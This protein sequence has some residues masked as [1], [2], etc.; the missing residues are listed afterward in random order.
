MQ[1]DEEFEACCAG[2]DW[3]KATTSKENAKEIIHEIISK[4]IARIFFNVEEHSV[5][6][7]DKKKT[8]YFSACWIF[9]VIDF[10]SCVPPELNILL[11]FRGMLTL[12]EE[13][14]LVEMCGIQD[15][16]IFVKPA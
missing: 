14:N 16:N 13:K 4:K 7:G 6:I 3:T 5:I 10:F 1:W 9:K 15:N 12:E 8:E 11:V 2:E